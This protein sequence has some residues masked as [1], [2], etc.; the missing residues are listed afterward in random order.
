M[1]KYLSALLLS[2]A[3]I[4]IGGCNPSNQT[5]SGDET[6][7]PY[8]EGV[9]VLC[10]GSYG[11]GNASLWF[12]D[13]DTKEVKADVFGAAN[14]ARLGDVGQSLY[15]HNSTLFVVVNN[16]G[17]VYALDATTGVVEGV[18]DNLV[19]PRFIAISPSGQK[20]YISQMYTNKIVV[21]DPRTLAVTG[22]I[23]LDGVADSEQ[24]VVWGGKL[25]V[26]AW[27]N[28]H[29]IAV[30]DTET[31]RQIDTFEVGVQP[32]SMVLDAH[33]NIWVVCDGGNEWSSL[34]EGVTMEQPSLWKIDAETHQAQKFHTFAA[35][36][37]FRSR[38]AIDGDGTTL[39]FINEA[40]WAVDVDAESFPSEPL[41]T[42]EGWG[43]YGLDV[44]P[45]TGD[46]YI[47]DA[48]DY[49]SNGEVIRYDSKGE[50]LD[51]FEVGLLPSKFAF[52]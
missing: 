14:D 4:L 25:F 23:A 9:F 19:S 22:E 24:M 43:Q 21:F 48:K 1:K 50:L 29:K 6:P 42:V 7:V 17:V 11:A 8:D 47:A 38:L 36:S 5:P 3:A 30:I 18:I 12:Y 16:S 45:A 26:A 33:D 49:V 37:Y 10:E 40:V 20:G 52:K 34:P 27:S 28:G 35:G 15:L 46:I 39:Y 31:D 51:R 32:Y 13:R 2:I 41:I 44:D